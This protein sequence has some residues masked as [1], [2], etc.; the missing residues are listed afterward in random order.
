MK[1]LL[2][3]LLATVM[4]LSLLAACDKA[5]ETDE[6]ET[7]EATES[8]E[9]G[10][11]A[12][13][14]NEEISGSLLEAAEKLKTA[15]SYRFQMIS[16]KKFPKAP[17]QSINL[18]NQTN[19]YQVVKGADGTCTILNKATETFGQGNE[20]KAK[21]NGRSFYTGNTGYI[22]DFY[23]GGD[24]IDK[25]INTT[26]Y[27]LETVLKASERI[28]V[29]YEA[30]STLALFDGMNPTKT[31]E[32]DGSISLVAEI[33]ADQWV[34]LYS[35]ISGEEMPVETA[36]AL[37]APLA[38]GKI[39]KDGYLTEFCLQATAPFD[40]EEMG[41]TVDMKWHF[42]IDG[43]N[44][45]TAE[46]PDY[47]ANYQPTLDSQITYNLDNGGAAIYTYETDY[48]EDGYAEHLVFSGF[49]NWA[50]DDY[51]VSSYTVLTEVEGMPVDMVKGALDISFGDAKV[52]R[53][54]IPAGMRVD[55]AG[56][57]DDT[58]HSGAEETILFFE[59]A[60]ENVEKT[61]YLPGETPENEWEDAPYVKGVY[62]AGQ[63]EL[64][65]GIPT[66]K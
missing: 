15:K 34:Q 46:T 56:Y 7:K 21:D 24:A 64:V 5:E 28:T 66:P 32:A 16:E 58:Y 45:T 20:V 14:E 50:Y 37:S 41:G 35:A 47:A 30:N 57:Y 40:Q 42:I 11:E 49:R 54:V 26:P 2:A 51:T 12:P 19:T 44:S 4:V 25:V 60:E 39:S 29:S 43:I 48:I 52:E 8:T 10:G 38:F 13:G 62:Y 33:T 61:F 59:D 27:T 22:D 6:K 1:K 31:V 18:L 53:L 23:R 65:D 55:I 17:A 3:L 36:Q 63:W 9:K